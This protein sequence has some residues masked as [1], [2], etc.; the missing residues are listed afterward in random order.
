MEA[1]FRAVQPVVLAPSA[2]ALEFWLAHAQLPHRA[3]AVQPNARLILSREEDRW[4][5]PSNQALRIAH[6]GNRLLAKGWVTFERLA[7]RFL[8]DAR[9][10]FVQLGSV[11]PGRSA[12]RHIPVR[13]TREMPEAMVEAVAEHNIDVVINWPACPETFCYAAHEAVAGGAFLI[14]H[15]G[16]GHVPVIVAG[17]ARGQGIVL[18][19]EIAL[20]A[21]LEQ[22]LPSML[23]AATRRRGV[24]LPE[25]GTAAWL[26][27]CANTNRLSPE[28]RKLRGLPSKRFRTCVPMTE[29]IASRARRSLTSTT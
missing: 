6:L 19:D 25:G 12:I 3:S 5:L 9:Y 21:L 8:S 4:I 13:V 1:F 15:S 7:M 2:V 20:H 22:S 23:A 27:R 29:S 16:A 28:L 11:N 17:A 10:E 26:A 24:L 18:P 14:T